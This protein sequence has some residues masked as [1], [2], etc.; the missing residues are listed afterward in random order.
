MKISY[1]ELKLK[2]SNKK[3]SG[4]VFLISND[5]GAFGATEPPCSLPRS[6]IFES[7]STVPIAG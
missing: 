2:V 6:E 4:K 1:V 3:V 7:N 5:G